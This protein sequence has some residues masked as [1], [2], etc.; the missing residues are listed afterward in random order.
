[1]QYNSCKRFIRKFFSVLITIFIIIASIGIIIAAKYGE[2]KLQESF[3]PSVN[4]KF[5]SNKTSDLIYEQENKKNNTPLPI[6]HCVCFQKLIDEG[7]DGIN[8]YN[9]ALN[10]NNEIIYPCKDWIKLYLQYESL[11][12]GI[13]IIVPVINV[14]IS[15][16]LEC[17]ILIKL[18]NSFYEI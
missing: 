3:N 15:I 18:T 9:V 6:T 14:V 5:I 8:S 11:K 13:I 2:N 7:L 16:A 1:M 4:C 12:T 17:K 10:K